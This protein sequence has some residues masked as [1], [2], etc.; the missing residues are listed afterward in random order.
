[1]KN[2]M[3]KLAAVLLC[4]AAMNSQQA[5]RRAPGFCLIDST[6]QWR[7]LYD[8]RGKVVVIEFMQTTCGHCAGFAPTLAA[9]AQKYAGKVQ[10]L[11]VALPPDTPK[12]ML[13][14]ANGHKLSYPLLM[15]MGQVAASYVRVASLN[16]PHIYL[17]D[18]EGMIRG[19]WEYGSLAK[20]IFE[21]NGL[22]RE[23]DKVLASGKK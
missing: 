23:I 2:V 12:T 16:F 20:D 15:D 8:Y 18:G 13:E 1:M 11:A 19:N 10:V 4:A 21:G 7:D 9:L 17:V 22:S 5:P 6:S 14:Y 3:K